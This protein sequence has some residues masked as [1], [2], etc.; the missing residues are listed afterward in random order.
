M[1]CC[2]L[3]AVSVLVCGR[4]LGVGCVV[5]VCSVGL[6]LKL[7]AT[8]VTLSGAISTQFRHTWSQT[9]EN[10]K[11]FRNDYFSIITGVS[12][13]ARGRTSSRST[14]QFANGC[15]RGRRQQLLVCMPC[16]ASTSTLKTRGLLMISDCSCGCTR[17]WWIKRVGLAGTSCSQ[18]PPHARHT[19]TLWPLPPAPSLAPAHNKPPSPPALPPLMAFGPRPPRITTTPP[20]AA[21]GR[22]AP[23]PRSP[24]SSGGHPSAA[25]HLARRAARCPPRRPWRRTT[26]RSVNSTAA[27]ATAGTTPRASRDTPRCFF[28]KC[29]AAG[30]AGSNE[31]KRSTRSRIAAEDQALRLLCGIPTLEDPKQGTAVPGSTTVSGHFP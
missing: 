15:A 19:N 1:L 11:L 9:S 18:T 12:T 31:T 10:V 4:D 27:T 26:R 21:T 29:H 25:P 24:R 23:T 17:L 3:C 6:N 13:G 30:R 22:R 2:V 20:N 8:Y 5:E 16:A 14:F 28:L 7:V